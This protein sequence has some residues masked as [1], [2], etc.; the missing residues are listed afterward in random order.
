MVFEYVQKLKNLD[1]MTP[2]IQL[3]IG[4]KSGVKTYFGV[5]MT[6]LYLL[7][8]C[9]FSYVII[10]TFFDTASPTVTE[11]VS[12]TPLNPRV[13]MIANKM[14]PV[15]YV[16][17]NQVVLLPSAA[18]ARYLTVSYNKF[19]LI[20]TLN[21]NGTTSYAF[22][23]VEMPVIPCSQAL[24]NA[25]LAQVYSQYLSTDFFKQHGNTSGLCPMFYP[26]ESFLQGGGSEASIDILVLEIYPCTLTDATK[27]A[28]LNEILSLGILVTQPST[29]L[30]LGNYTDPV[31]SYL[32]ADVNYFINNN[33]NQRYFVQTMYSEI[34]DQS[35]IMY[36]SSMRANFSSIEKSV[37]NSVARPSSQ[38]TCPGVK[39]FQGSSCF[40]YLEYQFASGPTK[41]RYTR[42]YKTLTQILSQLG[43]INSMVMLVFIYINLIYNYYAKKQLLVEKVFKFFKNLKAPRGNSK[44]DSPPPTNPKVPT[45]IPLPTDFGSQEVED[46]RVS[47]KDSIDK[48][49]DSEHLLN[50]LS[51]LNEKELNVLRDEAYEVIIKNLDV[52]T[53]VRE[54][55]N[56]KVLTHLLFKDYQHKLMPLISLNIQAKKDR[57]KKESIKLKKSRKSIAKNSV[58]PG[59]G[60]S[61]FNSP[62]LKPNPRTGA[63]GGLSPDGLERSYS[64][65]QK[66]DQEQELST[67]DIAL[68]KL[69][70]NRRS[71]RDLASSE[72]SL[73]DKIL[74]FCYEGLDH[75]KPSPVVDIGSPT[76]SLLTYPPSAFEPPT[77]FKVRLDTE[78]PATTTLQNIMTDK[79]PDGASLGN[80]HV[81]SN[82][83]HKPIVKK[84]IL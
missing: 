53:L 29:S 14:F 31:T 40:P 49:G 72:W 84:G 32:N 9:A 83:L 67:F 37:F 76:R 27:C 3:N 18:I 70:E 48:N 43:G 20:Q 11:E 47:K 10:L 35:Q 71:I 41:H 44:S 57:A 61:G 56:L 60:N 59:G 30:I 39:V 42:A 58:E 46:F 1:F 64:R 45:K 23:V 69:E 19:R 65:L 25:T 78:P 79:D 81:A 13:D 12:Q 36:T 54:V 51:R 2:P 15:V 34:W 77:D 73:E 28:S 74:M 17:A 4:G 38:I 68:A 62:G 22:D 63:G 55:N 66:L 21:P 80:P 8:V 16:M 26:E 75:T 50:P 82:K 24:K 6:V 7:A 52:I 33:I 5:A